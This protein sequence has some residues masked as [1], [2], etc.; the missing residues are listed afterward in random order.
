MG[1]SLAFGALICAM[2]IVDSLESSTRK[3][4]VCGAR[5]RANTFIG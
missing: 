5:E 3:C 2:E 1:N 4:L